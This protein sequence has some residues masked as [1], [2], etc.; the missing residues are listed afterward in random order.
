MRGGLRER[1]AGE[2]ADGRAAHGAQSGKG[3]S[4]DVGT[5]VLMVT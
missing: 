2:S 5:L 3:V 4:I 1:H